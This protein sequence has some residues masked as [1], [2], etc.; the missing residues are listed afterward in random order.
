MKLRQLAP[1]AA[2]QLETA[3]AR[4]QQ[5]EMTEMRLKQMEAEQRKAREAS[6]IKGMHMAQAETSMR[7]RREQLMRQHMG[8]INA[9]QVRK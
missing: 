4:T 9:G 8:D 2:A 6:R 5:P 7:L 3:A 1:E